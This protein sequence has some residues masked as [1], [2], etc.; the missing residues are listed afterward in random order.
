MNAK[1]KKSSQP[2]SPLNI[3]DCITDNLSFAAT[4]KSKQIKVFVSLIK[5][6]N[7]VSNT[8]IQLFQQGFKYVAEE[9]KSFQAV[10]CLKK[11]FFN[12]YQITKDAIEG[13]GVN[14]SSFTELLPAFLDNDLG[15]MNFSYYKNENR[16]LFAIKQTDS[17]EPTLKA[18]AST[19]DDEENAGEIVTEYFIKT[20]HSIEPIDFDTEGLQ[21]VNSI[22][23]DAH[24]LLS[25]LNDVDKNSEE[26]ELKITR[27]KM[28]I[29]VV[30]NV[31]VGCIAKIS[32]DSEMFTKFDSEE[33]SKFI[34]KFKFFKVI[35]KALPLASKVSIETYKN[36]MLKI[37]LMVKTDEEQNSQSAIIEYNLIPVFPDEDS[38]DEQ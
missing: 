17:G 15:S 31:Q 34:Y 22:I 13:F 7:F 10:G 6:L 38:E 5:A 1:K 19:V 33:P 16:V 35:M 28:A 12:D 11:E 29:K 36:G 14:L 37:Q 21:L 26:L 4:L 27:S 3:D 32:H 2:A 23:L 24:D 18:S 9:S 30:G 8:E 20:M 25:I